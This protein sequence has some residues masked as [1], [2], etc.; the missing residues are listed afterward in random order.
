MT[1]VLKLGGELL[2]DRGA[3]R[4]A[5]EAVVRLAADGPLVVVHG[6]GRAIDAELR[7]RGQ[8]P[9]FVDGLRVTDDAT[10]DTVVSVL[11]GR[12]NT[13]F[14]AAIGA[15]GGR[16][17]GLT[18]ADGRIGLSR[19]AEPLATV[20]GH[21]ADLGLVGEP[22]STDAALLVDL[23][24][25]GCIPVI[26]SIGVTEDGE[27]LN[28]NADVLAAHLAGVLA[29]ASLIV[30][31]GTP[32]VLDAAGTTVAELPV[33]AIDAMTASGV[34][35]S[36]MIAKLVACRGAYARGVTDV[37][38]VSGRGVADYRTA[39]GTTIVAAAAHAASPVEIRV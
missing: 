37:R 14:V 31:G 34:A 5:A 11:A 30:A 9:V 21:T 17:I 7:A 1:T 38:I 39:P 22:C 25:I 27:L 24:K 4:A 8:S 19:R 16:A 23:V 36:G 20:S 10:L 32:G 3:M 2:E 33:N 18:G 28:V 26:A 6:G 35:H 13:A 15:G 29:A 12:T